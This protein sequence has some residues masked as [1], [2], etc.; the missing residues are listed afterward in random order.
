MASST[1]PVNW[2][3]LVF[4]ASSCTPP[5]SRSAACALSARAACVMV[6]FFMAGA[7]AGLLRN[8]HCGKATPATPQE[9][10]HA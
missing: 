7:F 10:T 8:S 9:T 6:S 3:I 5:L 4:K 2:E 1:A